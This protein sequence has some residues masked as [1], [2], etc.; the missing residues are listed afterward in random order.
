MRTGFDVRRYRKPSV[1][2]ELVDSRWD[3]YNRVA[4]MN[5]TGAVIDPRAVMLPASLP[6]A[7]GMPLPG[8][9]IVSPAMLPSAPQGYPADGARHSEPNLLPGAPPEPLPPPPG[10]GP[11]AQL[12]PSGGP[13]LDAAPADDA[14]TRDTATPASDDANEALPD[15]PGGADKVRLSSF[16]GAPCRR[17]AKAVDRAGDLGPEAPPT[18]KPARRP[19]LSRLFSK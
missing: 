2:V 16:R 1:F 10:A 5:M 11:T 17:P 4:E 3:E 18:E 12:A 14:A 6:N 19:T 9:T 8:A 15:E 13:N 7:G